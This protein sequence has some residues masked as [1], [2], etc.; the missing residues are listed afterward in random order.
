MSELE[1]RLL[2]RLT[3]PAELSVAYDLGLRSEAF[4]EP[5][6]QAIYNFI[7]DYW[8][9]EHTKIAPTLSVLAKAFPGVELPPTRRSPPPGPLAS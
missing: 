8:Y 9:Q 1:R 4:I 7:V 3:D 2:A 5:V 6:C